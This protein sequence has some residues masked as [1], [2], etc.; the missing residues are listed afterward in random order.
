MSEVLLRRAAE[1][2][3]DI[4]F[5]TNSWLKS[6]RK[7]Q[8]TAGVTNTVYYKRHHDV[9]REVI[10]SSSLVVLCNP[11]D[12]THILGWACVE[13][14]D[15]DPT[16]YLHYVYVKHLMRGKGL[17]TKLLDACVRDAHD[18]VTSH[19]TKAGDKL[20]ESAD[21]TYQYDPYTGLFGV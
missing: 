14:L 12:K 5:I 1:D 11:E 19:S 7:A 6:Y 17:A 16:C 8:F 21:V 20:L 2:G 3:S 4:P 18:V 9:I 13:R 10:K 15:G